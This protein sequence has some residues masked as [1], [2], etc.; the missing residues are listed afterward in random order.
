MSRLTGSIM[1]GQFDFGVPLEPSVYNSAQAKHLLA[2][3]GSPNDVDASDVTPI[4]LFT[5]MGESV[6]NYL[7][8]VRPRV[9]EAAIGV[10]PL[11]CFPT[12]HKDMSLKE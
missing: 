9:A 3:A 2:E 4:P 5:S 8:A 10:T 12:S 6:M 7:G 11:T 1:P